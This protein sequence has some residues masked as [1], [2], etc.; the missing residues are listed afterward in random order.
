MKNP[1]STLHFHKLLFT[2]LQNILRSLIS[3][4][5]LGEKKKFLM[6]LA[7]P[8]KSVGFVEVSYIL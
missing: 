8:L 4:L 3:K 2:H 5:T 7:S 6:S 1:N